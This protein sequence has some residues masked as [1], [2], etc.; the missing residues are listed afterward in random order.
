MA[1]QSQ[2]ERWVRAR[3]ANTV[4]EKFKT[5]IDIYANDRESLL[6]D[7]SIAIANMHLQVHS[8]NAKELKDRHS[9]IQITFETTD[10]AQLNLVLSSL[11][12]IEGVVS[13][14]R[15]VQ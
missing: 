3:W 11:R 13:V 15:S 10:I 2:S 5:T 8:L 14:T 4:R 9:S 6:A 12:Q 1:D 7:I